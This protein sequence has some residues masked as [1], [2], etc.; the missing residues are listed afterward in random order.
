MRVL[1]LTNL[2]PSPYLPHKAPFN[3]YQFRLLGARHSVAVIAPIA[4]T[5][6]FRARRRGLP[7]LP[8]GRRV[9]LDGLVVDHP[10]F[11]FPPRILQGTYGRLFEASVAATFRR[12]V[13]EFRPD[14]V[15]ASWAYPDGWAAVRLARRAGLPVVIQVLGSDVLLL[16]KHR[17][18]GRL[19]F[20]ALRAADGVMTVSR[21]LAR[22]VIEGGASPDRVWVIYG[23]V[24]PALYHPGPKSEARLRVGLEPDGNPVILFV[25]NLLP[26]KGIDVLIDACAILAA[27]GA[28]FRC[29]IIGQ[30]PLAESL[31]A[32]IDRLGLRDRVALLGAKPQA[33]LPDWYR[34]ADVFVLPSHS[35]GVPNV[36]REASACAIPCVATRVGGIPEISD[37]GN[38][39]LIPPA[40]SATLAGAIREV[41]AGGGQSRHFPPPRT[42]SESID[43][44]EQFL[45]EVLADAATPRRA[46]V[47]A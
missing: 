28:R 19:T 31:Q 27:D 29:R 15:F 16:T 23:G 30:G 25:G 8:P 6:E 11:Y 40:N 7:P 42:W 43:E 20:D 14:L 21:D 10:R 3:R 1:A 34:A 39:R 17:R 33:E 9:E 37:C 2:F 44:L 45:T 22:R 47:R 46:L 13:A 24:D 36:L 35:E 12:R 5:D 41:L 4:W 32:R 38:I 18:R 26:V